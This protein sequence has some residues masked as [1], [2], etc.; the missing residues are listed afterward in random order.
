MLATLAREA[1]DAKTPDIV[2]AI[3][4]QAEGVIAAAFGEDQ[5]EEFANRWYGPM[6]AS[7]VGVSWYLLAL[8]ERL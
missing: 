1:K 7:G 2:L 6:P 8:S 3:V 4:G 5:A